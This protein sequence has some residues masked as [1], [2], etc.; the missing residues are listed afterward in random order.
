MMGFWIALAIGLIAMV[1]VG[2]GCVRE[3]DR[4][5]C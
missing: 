2:S 1:I 4:V 5:E 3:L